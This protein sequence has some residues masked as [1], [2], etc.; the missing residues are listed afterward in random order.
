MISTM[1]KVHPT[2]F[3]LSKTTFGGTFHPV[4]SGVHNKKLPAELQGGFT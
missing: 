2:L 1:A 3:L 4:T